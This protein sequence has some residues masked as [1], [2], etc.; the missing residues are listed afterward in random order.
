VPDLDFRV[1]TDPC[2]RIDCGVTTE[3]WAVIPV[4]LV[5]A[6]ILYGLRRGAAWVTANSAVQEPREWVTNWGSAPE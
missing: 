5:F 4:V 1:G 3:R 6:A 2:A